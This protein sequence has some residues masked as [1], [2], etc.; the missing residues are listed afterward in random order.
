MLRWASVS[1]EG[2][3]ALGARRKDTEATGT[4]ELR[5]RYLRAWKRGPRGP[6]TLAVHGGLS[7]GAQVRH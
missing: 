5:G 2:T 7:A 1:A 3:R 6:I 4:I